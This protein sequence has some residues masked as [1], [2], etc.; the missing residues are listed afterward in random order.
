MTFTSELISRLTHVGLA[1]AALAVWEIGVL[2]WPAR[3]S[4]KALAATVVPGLGHCYTGRPGA[5]LGYFAIAAT[6]ANAV[7]IGYALWLGPGASAAF[8]TGLVVLG[9]T[10]IVAFTR[11]VKLTVARDPEERA[12]YRE[13]RFREGVTLFMKGRFAKARRIFHEL[14]SWDRRDY[15]AWFYRGLMSR[16]EAGH[17]RERARKYDGAGNNMH[18][19]R[20]R[21]LAIIAWRKAL[22]YYRRCIQMDVHGKWLDEIASELI[23]VNVVS[24]PSGRLKAVS[25]SEPDFTKIRPESTAVPG[26]SAA[27]IEARKERLLDDIRNLQ[28]RRR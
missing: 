20:C 14:V 11:I 26:T 8:W 15:D 10:Y 6:S 17:L 3:R 21:R 5:G 18:G 9:V 24:Q 22:A 16:Y 19:A 7:I 13:N 25:A 28:S 2:L 4:A 1:L 12:L 23:Q 27:N